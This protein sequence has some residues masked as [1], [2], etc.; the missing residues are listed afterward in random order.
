MKKSLATLLTIS[1]LLL[2]ACASDK[3]PPITGTRI[4]VLKQDDALKADASLA[5]TP[6]TLPDD[7]ANTAWPQAMGLPDGNIGRGNLALSQKPERAWSSSIGDGSDDN[8]KLTARPIAAEEMVFTLDSNAGVRAFKIKNGDRVWSRDLRP[9]HYDEAQFG[10]GLAYSEG[11]IYATTGYGIVAA[12]DAKTGKVIWRHDVR[13]TLRSAPMVANGRLFVAAADGQMHALST[14]DGNELW[15]QAGISEP[16]T[17]IGTGVPALADDVVFVPSNAGELYAV[18]VQNGKVLWQQSLA[19]SRHAGGALPTLSS[20]KGSPALDGD[21]V[22]AASNGGRM[23]AVDKRTGNAAWDID[24]ASADTPVIVADTIYV[25]SGQNTLV[26]VQRSSGRI[27]ATYPLP[28]YADEENSKKPIY[29]SGPVI[30]NGIAWLVSSRGMLVGIDVKT[31][32]RTFK[33]SLPDN[34][35][36]PPIIA[37]QTLLVVTEDGRLTA[38]R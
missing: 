4:P 11:R 33:A 30:G 20:I 23:A 12:L 8:S 2:A 29:W 35:Y 38:F 3:N 18:R 21:R 7:Y 9:N 1:T 14:V 32:E 10:G 5:D 36:L 17:L 6:M 16:S 15:V 26:L 31:G 25:L 28:R 37:Q 34:A 13:G 24:L 22:Y 27:R 19:G